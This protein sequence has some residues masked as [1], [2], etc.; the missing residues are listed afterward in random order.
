MGKYG[1]INA[2]YIVQEYKLKKAYGKKKRVN[3]KEKPCDKCQY[4][5]ICEDKDENNL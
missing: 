2:G 3:C 5:E 1:S 4:E